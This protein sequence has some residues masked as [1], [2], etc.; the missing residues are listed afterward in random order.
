MTIK[1]QTKTYGPREYTE[2]GTR[3]KITATVRHDDSCGNGHNSFAIT[4]DG[5]ELRGKRWV[6]SFGGCCH[7]EVAKHFPEL[8]PFIKWHLSSTDG[9]M[10]YVANTMYHARTCDTE[11]VKPGDPTQFSKRLK[12]DGI[13]FTFS[14]QEKGF[15][16]YLDSV[17]DFDNIEV[18]PVPYDGKDSYDFTP[19]FSLTGFI[20]DNVEKKWYK[21]PFKSKRAAQ[22]FL[23]ALRT[24]EYSAIK[25]PTKWAK[26]TTPNLEYA[27]SS[28]VWPDA[29]LEQ[30]QDKDALEARLPALLEDFRADVE[31]LGLVW[32]EE[33]T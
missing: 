13:P 9:P 31:R 18:L 29:T 4:A 19:N 20:A 16:D 28:A 25:T 6:E 8:A 24:C 23:D 3:Y 5:Y 2:N 17:G 27:R 33:S 26:A 21:A 14:E 10:H 11:D 7:D 22:E 15:W 1:K 30:L 32:D 12:F